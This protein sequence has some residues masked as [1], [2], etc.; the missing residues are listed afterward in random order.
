MCS[1]YGRF[2]NC[3]ALFAVENIFKSLCGC[4]LGILWSA[5]TGLRGFNLHSPGA[6][7]WR[8]G[9]DRRAG[10][11]TANSRQM[12]HSTSQLQFIFMALVQIALLRFV[13]PSSC[14][15][16]DFVCKQVAL[17]IATWV[18]TAT[19][20]WWL[21]G[22]AAVLRPIVWLITSTFDRHVCYRQLS[23][24]FVSLILVRLNSRLMDQAVLLLANPG[25]S[26]VRDDPP[27]RRGARAGR[28]NEKNAVYAKFG[29]TLGSET[30]G[31]FLG[32]VK[33]LE[34]LLLFLAAHTSSFPRWRSGANE[35][36]IG[37]QW[38]IGE[39][40]SLFTTEFATSA[41]THSRVHEIN[42][43]GYIMQF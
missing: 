6:C 25:D 35:L 11:V 31:S 1:A 27:R 38:A 16:G 13:S 17:P 20:V 24:Q 36:T 37:W 21:E 14:F 9:N 29:L 5:G 28:Q 41:P 32:G 43:A 4:I 26:N 19:A 18:F 15:L 39:C 42:V 2:R 23:E 33:L 12:V 8:I 34:M 40:C 7:P 30:L 3:I 10:R 22:L